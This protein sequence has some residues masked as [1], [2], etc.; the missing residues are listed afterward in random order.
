MAE[1]RV[2]REPSRDRAEDKDN[3][4]QEGVGLHHAAVADDRPNEATGWES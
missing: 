1:G 3:N 4:G 2:E